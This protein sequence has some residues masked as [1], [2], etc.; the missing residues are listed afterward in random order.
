MWYRD[1]VQDAMVDGETFRGLHVKDQASGYALAIDF[2][3][4]F[5]ATDVQAPLLRLFR[6][7][8]V[9]RSRASDS[10][11]QW[12]DLSAL[13]PTTHTRTTE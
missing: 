2:A 5:S 11:D 3:R 6:R 4:S 12:F 10:E 8:R 13:S 1:F 9:P 7:Y